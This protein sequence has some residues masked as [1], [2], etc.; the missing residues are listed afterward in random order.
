MIR[1][2]KEKIREIVYSVILP[3]PVPYSFSQA[4]EDAILRFLFKEK[5]LHYISYLDIGTNSPNSCNNTYLF[6]RDGSRGV[7][8]EA[9]KALIP[10]IKEIRPQDVILNVGI[11]LENDKDADFYI[12]NLDGISTFD[13]EEAKNR[14]TTGTN[15]IIEVAKVPLFNIN[16][17][18]KNNFSTFPDLISID[19]EGL[20]LPV[21]KTLD[22]EK[23][24]I[25][26]ICVETCVYSET[27]VRP[28]DTTISEFMLTKGYEVYADTYI[29]T[30][31]VNKEWFYSANKKN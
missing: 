5:G 23:Y 21:L 18:I 25:P 30:I 29:N 13:K 9:N 28:K 16:S 15:K 26:V 11:S 6:Y 24:A 7:C 8:V 10:K 1:K 22:F 4:G 2:L 19:I 31:F 12:F 3:P 14:E 17:V 20:D 27:H